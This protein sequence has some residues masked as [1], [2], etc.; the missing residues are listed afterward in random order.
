MRGDPLLQFRDVAAFL[1]DELPGQ[2][3]DLGIVGGLEDGL[4]EM[5]AG[6]LGIEGD[7]ERLV[8][9]NERVG[10][11]NRRRLR[12]FHL[13]PL[14]VA[15]LH[16]GNVA[17]S[18]PRLRLAQMQPGIVRQ[19]AEQFACL[20]VAARVHGVGELPEALRRFAFQIAGVSVRETR[21]R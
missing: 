18:R 5:K 21:P 20:P 16:F 10:G 19:A 7:L 8:S 2:S 9:A 12:T 11:P 1:L 17:E 6:C 4:V 13:R 15:G 14:E 3:L